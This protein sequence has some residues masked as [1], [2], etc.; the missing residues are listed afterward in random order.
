MTVSQSL[1]PDLVVD[2]FPEVLDQLFKLLIRLEPE[3]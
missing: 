3:E 2:L 1:K